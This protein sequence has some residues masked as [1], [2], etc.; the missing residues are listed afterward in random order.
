MTK[1]AVTNEANPSESIQRKTRQDSA[2]SPQAVYIAASML[3]TLRGAL[4]TALDEPAAPSAR[5]LLEDLVDGM[6]A[7]WPGVLNSEAVGFVGPRAA[8]PHGYTVT[9]PDGKMQVYAKL[10][11]AARAYGCSPGSLSVQLSRGAGQCK[12]RVSHNGGLG[13]VTC[14]RL[15]KAMK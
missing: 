2:K 6:N 11:D 10:S 13:L 1:G 9:T 14:R 5:I 15:T 7:R 8:R 3:R 4:L 12:R